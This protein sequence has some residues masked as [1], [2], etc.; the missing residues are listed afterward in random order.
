M[1]KYFFRTTYIYLVVISVYVV[2]LMNTSPPLMIFM[3]FPYD[4]W[5]DYYYPYLNEIDNNKVL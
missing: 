3:G 5:N 2:I 4:S 1:N